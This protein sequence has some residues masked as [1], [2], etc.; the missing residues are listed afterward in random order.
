M[1][2]FK[3]CLNG[4]QSLLSKEAVSE[5]L[6]ALGR[7]ES[8]KIAW[9]RSDLT[10]S[11]S[12]WLERLIWSIAAKFFSWMRTAFYGIDLE[13]SRSCLLQIGIQI[14]GDA[15]LSRLFLKS[16]SKFTEI[17]PGHGFA[18][19]SSVRS[20]AGKQTVALIDQ[21]L[22]QDLSMD[23]ILDN[24]HEKGLS[25]EEL[26]ILVHSVKSDSSP[27][28]T[29]A[30]AFPHAQPVKSCQTLVQATVSHKDANF[31][32]T[33]INTKAAGFF[34][35]CT[36]FEEIQVDDLDRCVMECLHQNGQET[37]AKSCGRLVVADKIFGRFNLKIPKDSKLCEFTTSSDGYS[38]FQDFKKIIKSSLVKYKP[39]APFAINF[40]KVPESVLVIVRSPDE[41]WIFD[42][43]GN[44][45]TPGLAS[46]ERFFSLKETADFLHSRFP[47]VEPS[48][49]IRYGFGIF[50]HDFQNNG[51]NAHVLVRKD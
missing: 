32:Q 3:I 30:L 47:Y 2:D 51:F 24:T 50:Q 5:R 18:T 25:K 22:E 12:N 38:L 48:P 36:S 37:A 34:V 27:G 33:V 42:P 14:R 7:L 49:K 11:S 10:L 4:T 16:I 45:K 43:A 46:L 41:F 29:D 8:K 28:Q 9:I 40:I 31:S 6:T 13:E 39:H 35:S 21:L 44:A 26:L 20:L 19:T 1:S 17:A 15:K 23:E